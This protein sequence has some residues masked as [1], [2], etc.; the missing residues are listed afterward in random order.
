VKNDSTLAGTN[1]W[2]GSDRLYP[3]AWIESIIWNA[4]CPVINLNTRLVPVL[5]VPAHKIQKLVNIR[6]KCGI[7]SR[8]ALI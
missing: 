6:F 2:P 5:M 3:G 8:K 1:I 4:A 7:P